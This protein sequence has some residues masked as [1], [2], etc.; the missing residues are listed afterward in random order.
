MSTRTLLEINHDRLHDLR[1]RPELLA[2]VVSE[3]VG[4]VHT[5]ALDEA[6]SRG[7][8]L[9]LGHGVRLVLQYHHTT[10]ISVKTDYAE[11]RP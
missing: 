3:L 11:I 5:A 7:R 10:D 4:S 8:A 1:T 6:N 2:E 9:D